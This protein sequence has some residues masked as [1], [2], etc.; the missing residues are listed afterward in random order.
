MTISKITMRG[1]HPAGRNIKQVLEKI[2]T[3]V[4]QALRQKSGEDRFGG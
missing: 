2:E 4:M 1:F 3:A